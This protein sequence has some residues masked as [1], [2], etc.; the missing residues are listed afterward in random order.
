MGRSTPL[1]RPSTSGA[2]IF[3][4]ATRSRNEKQVTKV[5]G[6]IATPLYNRSPP[7]SSES[8]VLASRRSKES[9]DVG[10][11][12]HLVS[13]GFKPSASGLV[14]SVTSTAVLALAKDISLL[15]ANVPY[16][17]MVSSVVQQILQVANDVQVNKDRARELTDKVMIYANVI[18]SAL[19]NPQMSMEHDLST[20]ESDLLHIT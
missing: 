14:P 6:Q 15:F 12:H 4:G 3:Y 7:S 20:L 11:T 1:P 9:N 13:T 2:V 18:F 10:P 5:Q 16:I 8:E 19:N 17:K